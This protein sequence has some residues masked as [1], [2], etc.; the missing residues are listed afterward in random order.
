MHRYTSHMSG[1]ISGMA[2]E[3]A[4]GEVRLALSLLVM[5]MCFIGGAMHSTG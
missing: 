5:L 4:L 1:I 2:D 3:L